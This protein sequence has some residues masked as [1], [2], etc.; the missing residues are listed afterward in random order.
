MIDK[1]T[2]LADILKNPE[3]KKILAKYNLPCLTCPFASAEMAKL[4]IGK[5]C[6]M[7]GIPLDDL[8][9]DLNEETGK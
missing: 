3:N 7:Y 2:T 4:K 5:I 1:N 6:K 9:S 8:L